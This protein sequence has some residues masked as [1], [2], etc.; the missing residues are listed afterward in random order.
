MSSNLDPEPFL[1]YLKNLRAPKNDAS[2]DLLDFEDHHKPNDTLAYGYSSPVQAEASHASDSAANSEVETS[3]AKHS[4]NEANDV[5]DDQAHSESQHD[6]QEKSSNPW[7]IRHPSP[8]RL[9]PSEAAIPSVDEQSGHISPAKSVKQGWSFDD[10]HKIDKQSTTEQQS[11]A[12]GDSTSHLALVM[13]PAYDSDFAATHSTNPILGSVKEEVHSTAHS[14]SPAPEAT[15]VQTEATAAERRNLLSD[16]FAFIQALL[17]T[18]TKSYRRSGPA[19]KDD[20]DAVAG[21]S[22]GDAW[23]TPAGANDIGAGDDAWGTAAK[24]GTIDPGDDAWATPAQTNLLDETPEPAEHKA[25]EEPLSASPHIKD[26]AV[27][28]TSL[29]DTSNDL[30][31]DITSHHPQSSSAGKKLATFITGSASP[32]LGLT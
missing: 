17:T 25:H 3:S 21:A 28:A 23:T 18:P 16:G 15:G 1:E 32:A 20:D 8:T 30:S 24:A 2:E 10:A 5:S 27:P 14:D 13:D 22:D 26:F 7:A 29:L 12:N 31:N 19:A 9:S 11:I 4:E 6:V